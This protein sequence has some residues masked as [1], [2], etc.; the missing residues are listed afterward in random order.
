MAVGYPEDTQPN[1]AASPGA[2]PHTFGLFFE[3]ACQ[4]IYTVFSHNDKEFQICA[5][6]VNSEGIPE[7]HIDQI[8]RDNPQRIAQLAPKENTP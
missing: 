4:G 2:M 7:S 5:V 3:T 6:T 8:L 1:V